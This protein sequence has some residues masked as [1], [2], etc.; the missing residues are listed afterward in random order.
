[1]SKFSYPNFPTGHGYLTEITRQKYI[2]KAVASKVLP[3][4]AHRMAEFISLNAPNDITRPIQFWQLFSVLG[5]DRIVAIVKNFY[6]RVYNDEDWFR[7]SFVRVGNENHHINTQASMWLDVMG[8]GPAY[9]GA[10]FRLNFH[11]THNAS[12]LMNERGAKRWVKLMVQTDGAGV[13]RFNRS[14]ER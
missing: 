1:V 11:H 9:H 6:A 13:G 12:Q 5:Q 10:E 8:A 4:N 14:Y 2:E 3:V 7:G